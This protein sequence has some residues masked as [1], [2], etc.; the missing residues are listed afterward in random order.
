MIMALFQK[1]VVRTKFDTP[2]IYFLLISLRI[3]VEA[4]EFIFRGLT[5]ICPYLESYLKFEMVITL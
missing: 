2:Y 3:P 4:T 5:Y 1:G